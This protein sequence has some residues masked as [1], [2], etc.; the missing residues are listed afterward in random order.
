[1][2]IAVL[3]ETSGKIRE[4]FIKKGHDVVSVDLLDSDDDSEHHRKMDV[5]DF[6]SEDFSLFDLIIA[7]P[8]CTKVCVS[9]NHVYAEGKQKYQERIDSVEWIQRLWD[10]CVTRANKVCFE[11]P[12][13]VLSSMSDLPKAQYIQ[14]YDF[15]H[16]ASKKTG[17]FLHNLPR[18]EKANYFEPRIVGGKN[19]WGNQ[20]DSGQNKLAPSKN[21]WKLRS[22]TYQGIADSMADQW[23]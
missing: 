8:T 4:A 21:R 15:G 20:T 9:G 14:P 11:N 19:R 5:L 18:L 16:D 10:K 12:V 23:G 3:M 6:L 22:E 17:L 13:G 7:H 2:R 1:M